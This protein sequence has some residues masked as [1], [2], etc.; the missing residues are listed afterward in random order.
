MEIAQY[1][2]KQTPLDRFIISTAKF[3]T[4]FETILLV[5]YG[6]I[7]DELVKLLRG[8]Y[9]VDA[10]DT[11]EAHKNHAEMVKTVRNYFNSL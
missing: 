10:Y 7:P 3:S 6:N 2:E 11:F 5:D 4:R 9:G 8:N 1:I